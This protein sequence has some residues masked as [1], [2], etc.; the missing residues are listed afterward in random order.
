M[1][2]V[3][4]NTILG[5]IASHFALEIVPVV[6]SFFTKIA[7]RSMR[8]SRL[9]GTMN[10]LYC[11][12]SLTGNPRVSIVPL[13]DQWVQ[14]GRPVVKEQLQACIKELRFYR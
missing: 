7:E 10:A 2:L 4:F 9:R 13:L 12:I 5:K 3:R 8:A 6:R 1:K 14:E 11:R